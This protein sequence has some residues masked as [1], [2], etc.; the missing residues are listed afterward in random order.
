M[1]KLIYSAITSLDGYVADENGNFGW[2]APDEEVHQFVNDL[3]RP[4]GTY[5]YGRKMYETM[6]VW[7]DDAFVGGQSPIALD[8]ADLW[9][10]TDKVVYST[11]LESVSTPKTRLERA[12]DADAISELKAHA[13][14]DISVG[15]PGLA[16]HALKAGLV[17][18]CHFFLNPV[19]IGAGNPS[20]PNNLRIELELLDEHRFEGGVVHLH[21][22]TVL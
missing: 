19:V 7:G 20:L 5:L 16:A 12:F 11:T 22:R 6:F 10:A 9:R 4:I 8:Y 13:D 3:E 1:V 21:Y 14:R 2:A 17:D 15:G 18:E